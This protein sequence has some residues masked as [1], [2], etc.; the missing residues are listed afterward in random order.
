MLNREDGMTVVWVFGI[1]IILGILAFALVSRTIGERR[2]TDYLRRSET[3]FN[4]AEACLELVISNLTPPSLTEPIPAPPDT[5]AMLPN[6]ALYKTGVPDSMPENVLVI[7]L[8]TEV[9]QS[10]ELQHVIYRARTS[11]KLGTA[12]RSL[13]ADIR[14]GPLPAGTQYNM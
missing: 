4:A 1:M 14:L 6:D 3:A 9:F 12:T 13:V 7:K 5:W 8:K 10:T 2:I 11:G